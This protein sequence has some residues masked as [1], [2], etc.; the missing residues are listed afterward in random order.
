MGMRTALQDGQS[1]MTPEGVWVSR[2]WVLMPDSDA[3]QVGVI[4]RQKKVTE[5]AT[6]LAEAE[7]ALEAASERL[8]TLQERAERS[9]SARTKPRPV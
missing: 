3:G 8:E 7:E 4:E 2:D 6:Q 9:E 1:L 5:L